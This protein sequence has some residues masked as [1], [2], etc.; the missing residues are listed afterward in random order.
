M[1]SYTVFPPVVLDE[2][3]QP[4]PVESKEVYL[5]NPVQI[6][7]PGP[8]GIVGPQGNPGPQGIRGES[9]VDIAALVTHVNAVEPHPAYDDMRSLQ[10]IFENGL[11]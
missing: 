3:L 7:V 10:L 8:R 11:I 5:A 1:S 9:G 4:G 6:A 2:G